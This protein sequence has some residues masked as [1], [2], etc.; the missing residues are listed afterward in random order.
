[1]KHMLHSTSRCVRNQRCSTQHPH[2][3]QADQT[4]SFALS[5]PGSSAHSHSSGPSFFLPSRPATPSSQATSRPLAYASDGST[6]RETSPA[7]V[8]SR[9]S[10]ECSRDLAE[11]AYRAN[12]AAR[13]A[14]APSARA[15]MLDLLPCGTS[16]RAAALSASS[17]VFVVDNSDDLKELT[18]HEDAEAAAVDGYE[19]L[20]HA[21]GANVPLT[22]QSR[23]LTPRGITA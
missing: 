17:R 9:L 3:L 22:M 21:L 10:R 8:S 4:R 15:A 2:V 1:M 16:A 7:G 5:T 20:L 12:S 6:S 11:H 23:T 18:A 13:F 14:L 19:A